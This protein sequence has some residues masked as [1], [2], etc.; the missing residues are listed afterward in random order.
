MTFSSE[1]PSTKRL[2]RAPSIPFHESLLDPKHGFVGVDDLVRKQSSQ[3]NH[4]R[5]Q[6]TSVVFDVGAISFETSPVNLLTVMMQETGVLADLG[7]EALTRSCVEQLSD[8]FCL[9]EKDRSLR[10]PPLP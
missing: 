1:I 4:Q 8:L 6:P 5:S 9:L 3:R 10:A 2:Q 7:S